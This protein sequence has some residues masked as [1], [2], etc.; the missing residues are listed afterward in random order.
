MLVKYTHQLCIWATRNRRIL[1][2]K[3]IEGKSYDKSKL[4]Y[5]LANGV[6]P[7]LK[8]GDILETAA[9]D[10]KENCRSS[11][12][13]I[14]MLLLPLQLNLLDHGYAAMFWKVK[15]LW[16][17]DS[18]C[19]KGQIFLDWPD[20]LLLPG[21]ET[22]CWFWLDPFTVASTS[23]EVFTFESNSREAFN[24]EFGIHDN[25][26]LCASDW[27]VFCDVLALGGF[28]LVAWFMQ[29]VDYNKG[30]L[31]IFMNHCCEENANWIGYI[32]SKLNCEIN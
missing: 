20:L 4:W 18:S 10:K 24:M 19:F 22:A 31:P 30:P 2:R 16:R 12:Y 1:R 27:S 5:Q 13:C 9:D 7:L 21:Q 14:L 32:A 15:L 23:S 11:G 25:G 17:A 28:C 8:E 29:V 6:L 26:V 3:D